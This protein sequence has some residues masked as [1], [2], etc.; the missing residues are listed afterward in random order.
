MYCAMWLE[1]FHT[2]YVGVDDRFGYRTD[3][4]TCVWPELARSSSL[5][6]SSMM[7]T[8]SWRR[9]RPRSTSLLPQP[10][11]ST[12]SISSSGC[13]SYLESAARNEQ[14]GWWSDTPSWCTTPLSLIIFT[15]SPWHSF[16]DIV[17][18]VPT[19]PWNLDVWKYVNGKSTVLERWEKFNK[20]T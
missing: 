18:R 7:S 17:S 13:S 4:S 6:T 19:G 10:S 1:L 5:C 8:W 20:T 12:S 11:I 3:W 15:A 14:V 2:H 16:L 9:F